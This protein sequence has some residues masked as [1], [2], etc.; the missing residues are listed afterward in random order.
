MVMN[1]SAWA[2]RVGTPFPLILRPQ[3]L[4]CEMVHCRDGKLFF[5][6]PIVY[7]FFAARFSS[8][9]RTMNNMHL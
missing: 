6:G 4:K 8:G 3:L 7:V 9:G 5:C 2:S 1:D